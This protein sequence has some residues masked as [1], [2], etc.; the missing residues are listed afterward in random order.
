MGGARLHWQRGYKAA[1]FLWDV[2]AC[3][4]DQNRE[5]VV[6]AGSGCRGNFWRGEIQNHSL[7][8]GQGLLFHLLPAWSGWKGCQGPQATS[9]G[10]GVKHPDQLRASGLA[11]QPQNRTGSLW[12]SLLVPQMPLSRVLFTFLCG[13]LQSASPSPTCYFQGWAKSKWKEPTRGQ[14]GAHCKCFRVNNAAGSRI[15]GRLQL[16][17][18]PSEAE[19]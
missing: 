12:P 3:R 18:T 7:H 10:T 6:A 19:P 13:I 8:S 14:D 2:V 17:W 16:R 9:W 5:R 11:V 4:L 15:C 1:V